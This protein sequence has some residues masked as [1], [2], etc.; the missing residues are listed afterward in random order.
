MSQNESDKPRKN[1]K[2]WKVVL[3]ALLVLAAIGQFA[4]GSD[5]TDLNSSN[6]SE[7]EVADE[8]KVDMFTQRA[9]RKFREFVLEGGKGVLT[10]PEMREKF[11]PAYESAQFSEIPIVMNTATRT[12]AA[13]T[14][15]DVEQ[16]STA[17]KE[18]AE[19]CLAVGQ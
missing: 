10:I 7:V 3:V 6:S 19:A 12:M 15:E 16:F 18:L 9:C 13:L 17:S 2:T 5:S 1:T 8:P 11:R 14:A 4:G